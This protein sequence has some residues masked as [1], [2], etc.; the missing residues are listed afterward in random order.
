[1]RART[2]GMF[3]FFPSPSQ[4]LL[5]WLTCSFIQPGTNSGTMVTA[6]EMFFPWETDNIEITTPLTTQPTTHIHTHTPASL[7]CILYWNAGAVC[8]VKRNYRSWQHCK[9]PGRCVCSAS[10]SHWLYPGPA[11]VFLLEK[12]L[13][14]SREPCGSR[15]VGSGNLMA[16]NQHLQKQN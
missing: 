12:P 6:A 8:R 10:S 4:P 3:A 13:R 5:Q 9:Q 14:R 11:L 16:Q 15:T 7:P 2:Q 1:M